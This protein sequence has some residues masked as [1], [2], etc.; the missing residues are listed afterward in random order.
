MDI[1][2]RDVGT[3]AAYRKMRLLLVFFFSR[4]LL[5]AVAVYFIAI[6]SSRFARKRVDAAE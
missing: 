3:R 6:L 2:E 5:A 1:R 4:L